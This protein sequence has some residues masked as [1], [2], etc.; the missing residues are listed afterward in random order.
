MMINFSLLW[1]LFMAFVLV[2]NEPYV[3]CAGHRM[4]VFLFISMFGVTF[5][6]EFSNGV[7]CERI[8]AKTRWMAAL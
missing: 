1:H 8:C 3:V 2:N 7:L 5:R 4:V 6:E